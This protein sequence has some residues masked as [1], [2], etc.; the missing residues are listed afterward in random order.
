MNMHLKL[1]KGERELF[2]NQGIKF[3]CVYKKER[4]S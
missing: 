2:F 1:I 4:F 3:E